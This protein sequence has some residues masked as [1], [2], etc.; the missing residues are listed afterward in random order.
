MTVP[1]PPRRGLVDEPLSSP[2]DGAAPPKYPRREGV[3]GVS[4]ALEC[5]FSGLKH[6]S[7]KKPPVGSFCTEVVLYATFT[8]P[9]LGKGTCDGQVRTLGAG[10]RRPLD[11]YAPSAP[12]L[13]PAS[14]AA[15]RPA[16]WPG[17]HGP[18]L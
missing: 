1:P 14:P 2:S 6:K 7:F 13:S 12:S 10:E 16:S 5:L 18:G 15:R 9:E 17:S 4:S 8:T 3:D 11:E